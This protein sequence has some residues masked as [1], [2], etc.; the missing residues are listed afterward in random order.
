MNW[1]NIPSERVQEYCQRSVCLTA[2]DVA[3]AEKKPRSVEKRGHI[4]TYDFSS[5]NMTNKTINKINKV[6]NCLMSKKMRSCYA[7]TIMHPW[8]FD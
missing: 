8:Y 7:S 4:T 5:P 2:L 1:N 3:F 6:N